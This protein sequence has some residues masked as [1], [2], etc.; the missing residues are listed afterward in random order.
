MFWT[1]NFQISRFPNSGFSNF[2][3]PKFWIL[4]FLDLMIP[5]FRRKNFSPLHVCLDLR[6]QAASRP[7]ACQDVLLP[8]TRQDLPIQTAETSTVTC[9]AGFLLR[10][11]EVME[12]R[13]K[14]KTSGTWTEIEDF[15]GVHFE[16]FTNSPTKENSRTYYVAF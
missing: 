11:T 10:S 16:K 15:V 8:S 14:S 1:P 3:V 13:D 7:V 5:R 6:S 2:Q 4:Q 9:W 12:G